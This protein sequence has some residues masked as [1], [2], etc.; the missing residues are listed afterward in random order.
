M[1]NT[2]LLNNYKLIYYR[3]NDD[4]TPDWQDLNEKINKNISAVMM[5]HYFGIRQNVNNF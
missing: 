1:P 5:V 2:I 4:F 3:I